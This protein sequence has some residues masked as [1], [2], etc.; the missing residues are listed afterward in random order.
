[1]KKLLLS[2]IFLLTFVVSHDSSAQAMNGCWGT[3]FPHGNY[4]EGSEW[5]WYGERKSVRTQAEAKK[6]LF[7]YFSSI[8]DVKITTIRER[9][10]FFEAEIRDKK[11]NLIDIVIIDKRTGRI[12]SIY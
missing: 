3:R 4:C 10:W 6:I 11:N 2:T 12:R 7:E 9:K 1:M 5:G 8:E